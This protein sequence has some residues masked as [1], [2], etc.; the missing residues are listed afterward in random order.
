MLKADFT[1]YHQVCWQRCIVNIVLSYDYFFIY[2][3]SNLVKIPKINRFPNKC[4]SMSDPLYLETT[5][6]M[7]VMK[8]QTAALKL[9]LQVTGFGLVP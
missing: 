4:T 7:D 5:I 9:K 3:E 1:K 8:V 6:K 2:T